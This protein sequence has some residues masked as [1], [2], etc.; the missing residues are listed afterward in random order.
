VNDAATITFRPATPADVPAIFEIRTAVHEHAMTME[1]L[2]A[3]GITPASVV[4]SMASERRGWVAQNAQG[5][6]V[7]FAMASVKSN[8]IFGLFTRPGWEGR[9]CGTA[10]LHAAATHLFDAGAEVVWLTTSPS[11]RAAEFYHRRGWSAAGLGDK[12]ELRFELKR[13]PTRA[14]TLSQNRPRGR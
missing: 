11:S 7:A 14:A 2:A 8:F 3:E 6:I 5:Q 10:L 12:G 1:Q 9:G 4:K 13:P